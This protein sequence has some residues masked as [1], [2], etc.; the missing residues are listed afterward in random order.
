VSS[1][2]LPSGN[3]QRRQ[4]AL[5]Q[6][7][8][9]MLAEV[10]PVALRNAV[11]SSPALAAQRSTAQRSA[12]RST[13][14]VLTITR[15]RMVGTYCSH[16]TP[17]DSL[18]AGPVSNASGTAL[19]L[20]ALLGRHAAYANVLR[21]AVPK[22]KTRLSCHIWLAGAVCGEQPS[23]MG[24]PDERDERS[25]EFGARERAAQVLEGLRCMRAGTQ[26]LS[27]GERGWPSADL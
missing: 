8:D 23:S 10:Q 6:N 24:V 5:A 7:V 14:A 9:S 22:R 15:T 25:V 12:A 13:S 17:R 16:M 26:S 27:G 3:V 1:H 11:F 21:R 20:V 18:R 19:D 2:Q 4:L